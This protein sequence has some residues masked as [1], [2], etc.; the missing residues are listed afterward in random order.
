MKSNRIQELTRLGLLTALTI[1]LAATPL[2]YIP[3]SPAL[4][5][6]IM[7]VPIAVGGLAVKPYASIIL[8][9]VFGITSFI[10]APL[11]PLSAVMLQ[12]S[13][14]Y[15]II[16]VI[17]GR[18][19][20]GLIIFFITTALYKKNLGNIFIY[21]AV[22]ALTAVLNTIIFLSGLSLLFAEVVTSMLGITGLIAVLIAFIPTAIGEA[23]AAAVLT[24]PLVKIL[25]R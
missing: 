15:T 3:L 1:I 17:G 5:L 12:E 24:M 4:S 10:R 22:G 13:L 19:L 16:I 25:K 20:V 14:L 21:A 23:V 18:L 11:E 8:S 2:G 6:T 7:T 9:L